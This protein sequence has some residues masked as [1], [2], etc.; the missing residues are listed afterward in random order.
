MQTASKRIRVLVIHDS[1]NVLRSVCSVLKRQC[2]YEIIASSLE[3]G[4]ALELVENLSPEL[5]LMDL[6]IPEMGGLQLAGQ[7]KQS[8]PGIPVIML[9]VRNNAESK[10]DYS[11]YGAFGFVPKQRLNQELPRML[12]EVVRSRN[13]MCQAAAVPA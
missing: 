5:I 6:Q 4:D 8:Y 3:S 13:V 10:P 12:N 9:T 7:L 2:R 11:G 1:P